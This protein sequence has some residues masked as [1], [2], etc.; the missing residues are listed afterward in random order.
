[1]MRMRRCRILPP[2]YARTSAPFTR[3]TRNCVLGS[4]SCTVPSI[5]IISSFA[6]P[7]FLEK[8]VGRQR[9]NGLL[10]PARP[11][12]RSALLDLEGHDRL[13]IDAVHRVGPVFG[14]AVAQA[15]AVNEKPLGAALLEGALAM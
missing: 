1:M 9:G 12:F 13:R 6:M 5:S 4:T 7:A 3:R 11:V 2:A 10:A 14:D 15:L 8:S